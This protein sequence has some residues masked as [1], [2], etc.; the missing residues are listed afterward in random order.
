[1]VRSTTKQKFCAEWTNESACRCVFNNAVKSFTD[2]LHNR[3]RAKELI[4]QWIWM[5]NV[6]NATVPI[7]VGVSLSRWRIDSYQ[8]EHNSDKTLIE[9]LKFMF[10]F[11]RSPIANKNKQRAKSFLQFL[12]SWPR[13][14]RSLHPGRFQRSKL[15][16]SSKI[17]SPLVCMLKGLKRVYEV[18]CFQEV[19]EEV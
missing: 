13:T 4:R 8:P 11:W 10:L 9:Q 1:M 17:A 12:F 6:R 18:F 14:V 2:C 5:F 19:K 16:K 7:R 15:Q 3:S